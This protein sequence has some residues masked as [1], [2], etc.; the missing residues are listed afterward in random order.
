M[1]R[2]GNG[3]HKTKHTGIGDE[4]TGELR[5]FHFG[6]GLEQISL[7]ESLRNAQINNG[8]EEFQLTEKEFNSSRYQNGTIK[9]NSLRSQIA[10][11]EKGRGKHRKYLPYVFTEQG[12]TLDNL[13]VKSSRDS[14]LKKDYSA[15]LRS[16]DQ[17]A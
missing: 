16:S 11:L 2:S 3:N 15:M 9:E 4:H 13:D 8:V 5:E 17:E 7:T 12:V 14:S 1:K 6:D 10:T